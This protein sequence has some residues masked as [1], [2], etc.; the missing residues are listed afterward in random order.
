MRTTIALDDDLIAKAQA[1]T[2]LDEKSALV[3]EALKA[4][5][6]REAA[7]RLAALGGSNPDMEDIPRRR[8]GEE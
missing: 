7:R 8:G 3:R 5:I 2:G 4:L 1:Y 6:Q